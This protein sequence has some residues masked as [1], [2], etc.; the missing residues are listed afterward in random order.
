MILYV[1]F[2][3]ILKDYIILDN[4][5][6]ILYTIMFTILVK[7]H[8]IHLITN[9][10]FLLDLFLYFVGCLLLSIFIYDFNNLIVILILILIVIKLLAIL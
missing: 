10:L 1:Y 9:L 4:L 3:F 5:T 7:M 6:F 2:L 8:G